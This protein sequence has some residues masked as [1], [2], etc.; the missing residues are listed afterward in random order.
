MTHGTEKTDEYVV[1]RI[2]TSSGNEELKYLIRKDAIKTYKCYSSAHSSPFGAS[3]SSATGTT[4][5]PDGA[6]GFT[7]A[8]GTAN[9]KRGA[10]RLARKNAMSL[11][12]GWLS[13]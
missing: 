2:R 7:T 8:V 6:S 12:I 10:K 13:K 5:C 11:H 1:E 3:N 4:Q 9:T